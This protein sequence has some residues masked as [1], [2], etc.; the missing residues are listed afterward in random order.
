MCSPRLGEVH[1][2]SAL[3]SVVRSRRPGSLNGVTRDARLDEGWSLY[4]EGGTQ[5]DDFPPSPTSV[6]QT[7]SFPRQ[8]RDALLQSQHR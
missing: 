7:S 6:T 5:P 3:P 2:G 1:P 8:P 4:L